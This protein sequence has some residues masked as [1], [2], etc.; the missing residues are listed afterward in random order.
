[1][2]KLIPVLASAFSNGGLFTFLIVLISPIHAT[3]YAVIFL[4]LVDNITGIMK[5]FY[6]RNVSF[7]IWS[8]LSWTHISSPKLGRSISKTLVYML[9]IIAGFV[10]DKFIIKN[11][12]LIFT[13][14]LSGATA[15]REIK[16]IVENVEMIV[17]G[18]LVTFIK[19]LLKNGWKY[20]INHTFNTVS[21]KLEAD[22]IKDVEDLEDDVE[23]L[24]NDVAHKQSK[25]K[26]LRREII[27]SGSEN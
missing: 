14:A 15:L 16:S 8:W 1:M 3:L 7:K 10:I 12:V 17:G 2:N 21:P 25:I 4:V 11:D 20:T 13:K 19:G 27:E 26:R 9:L 6:K 18:G 22:Y 24:E 23:V 5:Y